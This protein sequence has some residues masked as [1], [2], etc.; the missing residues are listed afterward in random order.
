MMGAVFA[1]QG[2]GQ[3]TAG[4][5]AVICAAGFKKSLSTAAKVQNCSGVCGLA[6]DKMWRII[7]GFGAVPACIALYYRLT[8]PET[9]R[10]TFDVARDLVKGGSDA[11]AYLAGDAQGVPD[12]IERVKGVAN[13]SDQIEVPQ[14]SAKD[15]FVHY[16]KWKNAKVLL[17]T[18]GSWFFLDIAFYG[19]S[20]NNSII[21]TT[22][23]YSGGG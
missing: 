17:G 3:A 9:P 2:I 13:D 4:I 16:G 10:Y 6:V 12:E 11:K 7:I 22:I 21:L 19:V 18:A 15:F 5:V 14:A 1:M 20:L 23:G 8:I